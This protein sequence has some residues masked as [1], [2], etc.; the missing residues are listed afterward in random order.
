MTNTQS[1]RMD[2]YLA[3]DQ[4]THASRAIL[5]DEYGDVLSG[6][7][8]DIS[9]QRIDAQRVEQDATEILAS[10]RQV[11]AEVVA[12]IDVD[13]QIKACGIATQRSTML[14]WNSAGEARSAALSWQ[15]VR[16]SDLVDALRLQ[17]QMIQQISGL[18][19]SPHYGASKLHWLQ[20]HISDADAH[21]RLSPL[22]SYLLYHLLETKPYV[23]DHCNAQRTQLFDLNQLNW[24][25]A[26][27]ANFGVSSQQLPLC[28]PVRHAFGDLE[29]HGIAVTAVTGDQN[30]ALYGM[31][32]AQ[33]DVALINL[34]T[35]AFVLRHMDDYR[36]SQQQLT[37]IAVSSA[38]EVS[39][40]REATIN[41]A[42]S[43]LTWLAERYGITGIEQQ[44][45]NWLKAVKTPEIF[46]NSVGGLGSPWWR[47][48][49]D[50]HFIDEDTNTARSD[51]GAR[52]VG[53]IESI[54][55]MVQ[56]NLKLMQS[57]SALSL[58]HVSGGLSK[59]DGL[60]QRLADLS[61]LCV[62]RSDDSEAT[63]RGAAWLAA[64]CPHG[65][66][67]HAEIT[68]FRPQTDA[69][70]QQRYL[71]FLDYLERCLTHI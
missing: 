41:G 5:F 42:G 8:C 27:C 29:Q 22:V 46:F 47:A 32:T 67:Q 37:G 52:V 15:D 31:T 3:I 28:V 18:P 33:T 51:D 44:L 6:A 12:D 63:A 35:G 43:A 49:I 62:T 71:Y 40:V 60:C 17:Q 30:A 68:Q 50:P 66:H 48:D 64:G 70:L 2:Y 39:F 34:G 21:L 56:S 45:P 58:L 7:V 59:L 65:W 54:L 25:D 13:S 55:F 10:V 1:T 61:G 4:G 16:G 53:V 11:V 19:L 9:L 23:V 36:V 26:L 38:S 20:Q 14:A 24:S 57:E 69:A